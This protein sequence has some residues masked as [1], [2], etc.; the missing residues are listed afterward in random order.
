MLPDF[1]DIRFYVHG[2]SLNERGLTKDDLVMDVEIVDDAGAA[3][4]LES[5]GVVLPF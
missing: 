3:G 5:A 4:L 1:G 2:Q